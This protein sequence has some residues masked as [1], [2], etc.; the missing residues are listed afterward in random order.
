MA[1][2]PSLGKPWRHRLLIALVLS[3]WSQRALALDLG[4]PD[5]LLSI[6]VH[7]FLS[8]GYI[9]ST[10]NNY[11]A[12]SSQGSFEFTEAGINFT[13]QLTENLRAGLQLFAR[14]LGP[15]GDYNVKFDW[16]YLD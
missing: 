10:G 14:K 8:Q 7:A 5:K 16:F 9:V 13:K 1:P 4:S 6:E 15:V 11:L 2:V 12:S 3:L